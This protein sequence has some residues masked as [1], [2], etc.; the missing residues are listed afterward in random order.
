MEKYNCPS[1]TIWGLIVA[2]SMFL[3]LVV[4]LVGIPLAECL[5]KIHTLTPNML[6]KI[7]FRM[8]ILAMQEIVYTLLATQPLLD[9][10]IQQ[11]KHPDYGHN[12]SV[13]CFYIR[14]NSIKR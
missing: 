6:K 8:F 10:S 5:P 9:G 2:N 13:Y 4:L 7:G 1:L 12:L 11:F 14:A 3:S